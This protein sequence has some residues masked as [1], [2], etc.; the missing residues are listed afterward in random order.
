[1]GCVCG[2]VGVWVCVCG[3]VCGCVGGCYLVQSVWKPDHFVGWPPPEVSIGLFDDS[4]FFCSI[5]LF[6]CFLVFSVYLL[7]VHLQRLF[8]AHQ[9]PEVFHRTPVTHP[10]NGK[11][12]NGS[13]IYPLHCLRR[14]FLQKII[15]FILS[16]FQPF[17][18]PHFDLEI[19]FFNPQC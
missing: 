1:M 8:V 12:Y 14:I 19:I 9:V 6:L 4:L 7:L 10:A 16:A 17:R 18:S 3:C 13:K 2:F 5:C 11:P 15:N